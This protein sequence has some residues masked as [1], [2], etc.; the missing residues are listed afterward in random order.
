MLANRPSVGGVAEGPSAE[1]GILPDL[2]AQTSVCQQGCF[3]HY[4]GTI[5]F[6]ASLAG[7]GANTT[8]SESHLFVPTLFSHQL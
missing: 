2:E 7:A 4:G 8:P 3:W 5:R 1:D 6:C